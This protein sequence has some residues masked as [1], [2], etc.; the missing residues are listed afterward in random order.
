MG[1][2]LTKEDY[3]DIRVLIV[4]T[5]SILDS[6]R[7]LAQLEIEGKKETGEFQKTVE[8]LKSSIGMEP[9]IYGRLKGSIEKIGAIMDYIQSSFV[10]GQENHHVYT[11]IV[12]KLST[13]I[14]VEEEMRIKFECERGDLE[15]P[16]LDF[17]EDSLMKYAEQERIKASVLSDYYACSLSI[18][19][20]QMNASVNR[21]IRSYLIDVKYRYSFTDSELE[22]VLIRENFEIPSHVYLQTFCVSQ[23]QQHS[24]LEIRSMMKR[25]SF[26]LVQKYTKMLLSYSD[27]MLRDPQKKS[28]AVV[29]IGLLRAG[30]LFLDDSGVA[31]ANERFHDLLEDSD[32]VEVAEMISKAYRQY[33]RD[34]DIPLMLSFYQKQK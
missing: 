15:S 6:T 10:E 28:E 24:Y 23:L 11:R 32:C 31:L 13:I 19:G 22:Q 21:D 4:V 18:L 27:D 1:Y 20:K 33:K 14:S 25:V 3:E 17:F 9:V 34:K 8:E 30:L 2:Q 12:G 7:L 29:L 16:I 26:P 5:N